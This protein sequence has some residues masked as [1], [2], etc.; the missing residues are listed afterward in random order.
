VPVFVGVA[1][2]AGL[3]LFGIAAAAFCWWRRGACR[4]LQPSVKSQARDLLRQKEQDRK[5]ISGPIMVRHEGHMHVDDATGRLEV[6]FTPAMEDTAK[7]IANHLGFGQPACVQPHGS[8]PRASPLGAGAAAEWC[9]TSTNE[10]EEWEAH[11]TED[12]AGCYFYNTR[13]GESVW[14]L[15]AR[16]RESP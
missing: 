2:A 14:E 11:P 6:A 5:M 12:G 13:T 7:G 15:P 4:A 10:Y 3:I 16:A 8:P 9:T 1:A